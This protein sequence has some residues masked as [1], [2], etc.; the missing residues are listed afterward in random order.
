MGKSGKKGGGGQQRRRQQQQRRRRERQK[1]ANAS[2]GS[3]DSSMRPS[4]V[5]HTHSHATAER[6]ENRLVR[7][8][9]SYGAHGEYDTL[10][11]LLH[12]FKCTVELR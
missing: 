6:W 2:K 8:S 5:G 4:E 11:T 7:I 9:P 1:R 12:P 10:Y 3:R